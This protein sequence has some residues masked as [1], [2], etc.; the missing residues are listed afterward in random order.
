[1]DVIQSNKKHNQHLQA[2]ED[3]RKDMSKDN[4]RDFVLDKTENYLELLKNKSIQKEDEW[5]A[6]LLVIPLILVIIAAI[7]KW[8]VFWRILLLIALVLYLIYFRWQMI[9]VTKEALKVKLPSE[10]E[11][12]SESV[13]LK[14]K[15]A[16][17]LSGLDVKLI[18][19][20]YLSWLY[21][22]FCPWLLYFLLEIR[23]SP[24]SGMYFMASILAA[25]IIGGIFWLF[26]FRKD[27]ENLEKVSIEFDTY[28]NHL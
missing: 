17:L 11:L 18:R 23:Q 7:V 3:Q 1:M 5:I 20:K 26:H 14:S 2:L 19:L 22:L 27:I 13:W 28:Q 8:G 24:P 9:Q 21:F 6:Y 25:Y 12:R 10:Q 15:I 4:Y 16:Y